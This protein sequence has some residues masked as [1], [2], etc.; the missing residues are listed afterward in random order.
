MALPVGP[1]LSDLKQAIRQQLPEETEF[2]VSENRYTL[3]KLKTIATITKGQKI[4]YVTDVS[5]TD[6]NI[7]KII[8]FVH[9]SDTLYCEAYFMDKDIDRALKDFIS[10]RRSPGA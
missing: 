2:I 10:P 1:W 4:S 5:I 8:E 3:E 6:D 9:N 7:R